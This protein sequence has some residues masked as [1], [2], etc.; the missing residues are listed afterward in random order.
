MERRLIRSSHGECGGVARLCITIG[1]IGPES[2][3]GR[4]QPLVHRLHIAA[5]AAVG[6][7]AVDPHITLQKAQQICRALSSGYEELGD[8]TA[9]GKASWCSKD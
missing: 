5:V 8:I 4:A 9:A 2:L 7:A 3:P 6:I 1:P